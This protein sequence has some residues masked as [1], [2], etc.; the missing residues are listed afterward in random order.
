MPPPPVPPAPAAPPSPDEMLSLLWQQ[1]DE[2]AFIL[3]DVDGNVVGWRGGAERVLGYSEAEV[4]GRDIALIFTPEDLRKGMVA[5]EQEIA[6]ADGRSEDDR[7][8]VRKDGTRVWITGTMT[9]LKLGGRLVGYA[10]VL[11]DRTDLR[12]KIETW[13]NRAEAAERRVEDR[14]AFFARLTHEVRNCVAPMKNAT[15]LLGLDG[16]AE[17][18]RFALTVLKRQ[19]ALL[20]RMVADMAE[21]ARFGAGKLQLSKQRFDLV[22]DLTRICDSLAERVQ[23]RQLELLVLVPATPVPI[24][25][26]RERVHQVVY[27]LLDNA[28]K[29][30]PA[31]GRI[32]LKCTTEAG[33][34]VV[35]VQDEG[36]GIAP[37]LLPTIFELFTQED[38]VHAEGGFGV[39]LSLVKDLVRAHDGIVEARSPGKGKGSEF[40][41]RLPLGGDDG[42]T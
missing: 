32:W 42:A 9:A 33:N 2:H 25:A 8:H 21:V 14:D 6:A 12:T 20:Q 7:W 28:I 22:A 37:E 41:V 13:K 26:D 15:E 30:T 18:S 24:V 10:K 19:I 38:F 23:Q 31:G 5:L 34:A 27:N 3:L 39:G 40:T 4:L 35:R 11:R 1:S 17:R 16:D 29:Y 36:V